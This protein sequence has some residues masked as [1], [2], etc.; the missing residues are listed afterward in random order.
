M[1]SRRPEPAPPRR[2]EEGVSLVEV[3]VALLLL[4]VG[5]VGVL[6]LQA[7]AVRIAGDAENM[8]RAVLLANEASSTMWVSRTASL[9]AATVTAWQ[10]RVADATGGGLRDGTGAIA[11]AG[12]TAT[13]TITWRSSAPGVTGTD[14]YVTQVVI[15]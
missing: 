14:R 4:S 1:R 3:L 10:N 15:P 11:V 12:N 9:P 13:I 2:L 6:G 5:L 7:R 8:T